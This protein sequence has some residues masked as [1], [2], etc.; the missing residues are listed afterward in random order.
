MYPASH[1]LLKG[2]TVPQCIARKE[3]AFSVAVRLEEKAT[4]PSIAGYWRDV[5]EGLFRDIARLKEEC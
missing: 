5:Q 4:V 3:S 2:E 1:I